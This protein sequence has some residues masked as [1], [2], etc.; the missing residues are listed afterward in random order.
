MHPALG[1]PSLL[2]WEIGVG[3]LL[4]SEVIHVPV[5]RYNPGTAADVQEESLVGS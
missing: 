2:T 4:S 3:Q 1:V 5:P